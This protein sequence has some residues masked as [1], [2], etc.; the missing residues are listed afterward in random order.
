MCQNSG[1][2]LA[3]LAQIHFFHQRRLAWKA[4]NQSC[5]FGGPINVSLGQKQLAVRIEET[6]FETA[7]AGVANEDFHF[8]KNQVRPIIPTTPFAPRFGL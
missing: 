4:K 1:E 7:G 3:V 5:W 8:P 2:S 6:D